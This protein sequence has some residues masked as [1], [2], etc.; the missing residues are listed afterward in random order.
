M[1]RRY[2]GGVISA[3]APTTSKSLAA[4]VWTLPQQ[5]V[6]QAAGTWP[7]QPFDFLLNLYPGAP[8]SLGTSP[9]DG[10]LY[11]SSG[12]HSDGYSRIAKYNVQGAIQWQK[13]YVGPGCAQNS[14]TGLFVNSSNNLIITARVAP[15]TVQIQNINISTGAITWQKQINFAGGC[16]VFNN[17]PTVCS[18]TSGNVYVTVFLTVSCLLQQVVIKLNSSGVVQWT[19]FLQGPNGTPGSRQIA[20]DA[21]G[22]VYLALAQNI[23]GNLA[24]LLVKLNSSGAVQW[25][26]AIRIETNFCCYSSTA[27]LNSLVIDSAGN[28]YVV[29]AGLL[30]GTRRL[31]VAK[32]DSSG[33]RQWNRYLSAPGGNPI[34]NS[35]VAISIDES[36]NIYVTGN[37]LFDYNFFMVKYNSSGTL[38]W[39]R[40]ITNAGRRVTGQTFAAGMSDGSPVFLAPTTD[41]CS[42]DRRQFL[43]K[44]PAG[45]TK[46]G[47]YVLSGVSWVYAASS[48][49]ST[50]F[51]GTYSSPGPTSTQPTY[52]TSDTSYADAASSLTTATTSLT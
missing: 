49:T 3:T 48:L 7:T 15:V 37:Y 25:Q 20:V 31:L 23:G 8:T 36:D 14:I 45:G 24:G 27:S 50:D 16:N 44:I 9:S 39:Q 34:S 52:T 2:K 41:T 47:T 18:D 22:N 10:A 6:A 5:M 30:S 46:T 51:T 38:Q 33:T 12:S 17:S 26:R 42:A 4:G 32:Y 43:A 21:S 35:E 28:I 1:S 19:T 11:L 40:Q 13:K 29:G